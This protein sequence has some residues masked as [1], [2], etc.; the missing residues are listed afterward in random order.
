M[1]PACA[2]RVILPTAEEPQKMRR[3]HTLAVLAAVALASGTPLRADVQTQQKTHVQFAGALGRMVNMFGGKAAKEGIVQTIAV[4][5]DRMMTTNDKTAEL[6]DMKEEKVY[7]IDLAS[8]SYKVV[9]FAELRQKMQEAQAKAKEQMDAAKE[10]QEKQEKPAEPQQKMAI[11]VSTHE[12]G[13]KKTI[14]GFDCKQVVTTVTMHDEN[15]TLEQGGGM[16]MTSDSWMTSPI[17]AMKEVAAF[18][19][20]YFE[21]LSGMD[22][23]A[24]AEQMAQALAMYPQM[25]D[26]IGRSRV[27]GAKVDGTPISTTANIETVQSPEQKQQA[28]QDQPP[29]TSLGGLFAKKMMKKKSE[30][31]AAGGD[32]NRSSLM[33]S[34][35]EVLSVATSVT[36]DAVSIPEG[37]KLKN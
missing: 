24:A 5:G 21:K 31:S 27:E 12:T 22:T 37:F 15:K 25:K 7:N 8:K 4:K 32:P 16:V 1:A 33:T 28:Q 13:Q 18:R 29:P 3:I 2:L 6:I 14:N 20:R 30:D 11:D 35:I 23:Q 10:K 9:T 26:L 19:K 17:P 36:A 34:T